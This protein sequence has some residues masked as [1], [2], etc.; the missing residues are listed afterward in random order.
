MM[1]GLINRNF[2]LM[3]IPTTICLPIS[4]SVEL[5]TKGEGS[6]WVSSWT[7][8]QSA[9]L[10][11]SFHWYQ[12]ILHCDRANGVHNV[13]V[14][15]HTG[16]ESNQSILI[17]FFASNQVK[18]PVKIQIQDVEWMRNCG[19]MPPP[20]LKSG[21]RA[22]LKFFCDFLYTPCFIKNNP[23]LIAHN[24]GKYWPIFK[25]TSL[26]DSAVNR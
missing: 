21:A 19:S 23:Y 13:Y 15:R 1:L 3:T 22:S 5:K 4:P 14:L 16:R 18:N 11:R 6:A 12:I 2:K 7:Q 20:V 10:P 17:V 24:F 9:C 26:S 25:I 8:A